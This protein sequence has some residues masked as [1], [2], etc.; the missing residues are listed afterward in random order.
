MEIEYRTTTPWERLESVILHCN[1][2]TL[3]FAKHL[4]LPSGDLL[5]QIKRGNYCI[6]ER[7]ADRI[8]MLHPEIDRQWLLTGK[9]MIFREDYDEFAA[10]NDC[11]AGATD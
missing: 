6:S 2:T 3:V 1:M 4:G 8:V 7:L 9:G 11:A 10:S 5:F